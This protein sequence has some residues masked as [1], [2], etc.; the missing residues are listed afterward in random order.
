MPF[1]PLLR[2]S[3]LHWASED[4]SKGDGLVVFEFG[5]GGGNTGNDPCKAL[6]Q[7]PICKRTWNLS[8]GLGTYRDWTSWKIFRKNL[9]FQK[10]RKMSRRFREGV[11]NLVSI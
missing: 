10:R 5:L 11:L 2:P 6:Q 1:R 3:F 8:T 9:Q 7:T 4:G